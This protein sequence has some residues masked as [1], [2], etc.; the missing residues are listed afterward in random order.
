MTLDALRQHRGLLLLLGADAFFVGL[1]LIHR[2]T[3]L[4][5]QTAYSI[6]E[7]RSYAELLQYAKQASI[8]GL[9]GLL[10][11]RRR[12]PA[13]L[14]WIAL[15]A[16]LL[17]DDAFMI[18]ERLGVALAEALPL[19][20]AAGLRGRDFGELLISG[21]AG[22]VL[23]LV[24]AIAHR[25][26]A[27]AERAFARSLVALLAAL[28]VFGVVLDMGQIM[29]WA[30]RSTRRWADEA[31]MLEDGGEMVVMTMLVV[32]VARS[33]AAA[34]EPERMSARSPRAAGLPDRAG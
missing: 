3:D 25:R 31:G 16:Y 28:V 24:V 14:G 1:H 10:A 32:L 15:F 13:Y 5:P 20:R 33:A 12:A 2:Y 8:L 34:T 19:R 4:L 17:L 6:E 7:D 9:L 27:A 23:L 18:H 11:V 29:L 26:S 22:A 21:A 30:D